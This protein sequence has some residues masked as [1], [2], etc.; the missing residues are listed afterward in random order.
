MK[1]HRVIIPRSESASPEYWCIKTFG[2]VTGKDKSWFVRTYIKHGY[3]IHWVTPPYEYQ[4]IPTQKHIDH[5]YFKHP[6]D[7]TAFKLKWGGI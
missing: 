2:M 1:Y 6:E 4:Q 5:F 7:A 3:L